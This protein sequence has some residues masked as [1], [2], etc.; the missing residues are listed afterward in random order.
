MMAERLL[1]IDDEIAITQVVGSI[2]TEL[3]VEF[4]AL[5]AS[6]T[7]AEVFMEYQPDVVIIDI[8]MPGKD[9]IDVLNDI[10]NTGIPTRIVLTTGVSEGYLRLAQA[11][12]RFHG[13]EPFRVLKKPFRHIE[14]VKLLTNVGDARSLTG[15]DT[16]SS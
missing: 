2:A 4:R 7:A 13:V 16:V 1:I 15:I 11:I 14:L 5:N 8:I 12:A 3:G 9:G 10:M 6:L